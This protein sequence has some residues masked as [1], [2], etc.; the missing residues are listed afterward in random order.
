[1]I[2]WTKLSYNLQET[3]TNT[4]VKYTNK[5]NAVCPPSHVFVWI[6]LEQSLLKN[7]LSYIYN[8]LLTFSSKITNPRNRKVNKPYR[9]LT[10]KLTWMKHYQMTSTYSVLFIDQITSWNMSSIYCKTN[11]LENTILRDNNMCFKCF[12]KSIET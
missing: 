2:Y 3:W 4:A 11:R 8:S 1:M 10:R 6:F 9:V 5:Q 7:T 12:R